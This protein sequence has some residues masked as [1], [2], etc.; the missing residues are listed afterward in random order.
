VSGAVLAVLLAATDGTPAAG[1]PRT[2]V[3][4]YSYE[5]HAFGNS[6]SDS[7]QGM[8]ENTQSASTSRSGQVTVNVLGPAE[9]GGW[10]VAVSQTI[11]RQAQPLQTVQCSVYGHTTDI[12]CEGLRPTP[13]EIALLDFLGRFFW[14]PGRLDAKSHWHTS[15]LVHGQLTIDNDFTVTKTEGNVV[16]LGVNRRESGGGYLATYAGT[17]RY[18]TAAGIPERIDLSVATQGSDSQGDAHIQLKLVSDSMAQSSGTNS[19]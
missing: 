11:D 7:R 6:A 4:R 13:E 10:V 8:Q 14:E 17:A 9:D 15:P 19:H 1:P 18:D 16:T 12:V 2:L 3:Y 5:E